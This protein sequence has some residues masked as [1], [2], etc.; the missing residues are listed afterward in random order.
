MN[1]YEHHIGDYAEATAHLSLIEH[2]I[3]SQLI[4]K[5]Y[6]KERPIA[7][8]PEVVQRLVGA[9]TKKERKAVNTIL[10]EFFT[11]EEDGW[12]NARCDK[13]IKLYQE[14]NGEREQ[15]A[16]HEKDRMSRHREERA[17]LFA[18]LRALDITPKWDTPVTQLRE[19]LKDAGNAPAAITDA[20]QEHTCN[21]PATRTDT[22]QEHTCNAPATANHTPDTNTQSPDTIITNTSTKVAVL[23]KQEQEQPETGTAQQARIGLL[24]QQLRNIGIDA[25]PQMPTW[26][27]LLPHYSDKQIITCAT[28]AARHSRQGQRIHLNYLIP[29]LEDAVITKTCST[30]NQRQPRAEN[31]D[32]LNYGTSGKL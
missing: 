30:V 5:Y 10:K 19:M 14:G 17:R 7:A 32:K 1:Y 20:E 12:H 15:K 4:R 13:E 2:G 27:T 8:D 29:K 23:V 18:K 31:F 25:T 26:E 21:A 24:C 9:R 28:E 3:Y 11:L 16:A 22:E 6:A